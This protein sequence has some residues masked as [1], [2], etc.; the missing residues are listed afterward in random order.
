MP[1]GS[2]CYPR[3]NPACWQLMPLQDELRRAERARREVEQTR[4]KEDREKEKELELIRKQYL[5]SS[6]PL[7]THLL[8]SHCSWCIAA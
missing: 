8:S 5:V 7:G 6:F 4:H 2:Q 1:G 3:P